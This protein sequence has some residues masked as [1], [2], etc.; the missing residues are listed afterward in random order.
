MERGVLPGHGPV[1]QNDVVVCPSPNGVDADLEGKGLACRRDQLHFV[2]P[3]CR[4]KK[5]GVRS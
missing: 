2:L 3:L 1:V 4:F 5:S